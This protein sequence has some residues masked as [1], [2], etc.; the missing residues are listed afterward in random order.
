MK[1]L[2][3]LF[4]ND[5]IIGRTDLVVTKDNSINADELAAYIRHLETENRGLKD[6]TVERNTISYKLG[7]TIIDALNNELPRKELPAKLLDLYIES[8]KRKLPNLKNAGLVDK[9]LILLNDKELLKSYQL[10]TNKTKSSDRKQLANIKQSDT[11]KLAA[12]LSAI[13]A[14]QS[15]SNLS[16]ESKNNKEY[17]NTDT[18]HETVR[19]T[20]STTSKLKP[21][22]LVNT[23]INNNDINELAQIEVSAVGDI[24]ELSAA[25]LYRLKS[26]V[27]S[28]KA[29][30]LLSFF[31]SE[32][33]KVED[34]AL[35]DIG[36]SAAFG[37]HFRYLN[38][39]CIDITE[40]LKDIVKFEIPDG[41]ASIKI[42]VAAMGLKDE[43]QIDIRLNARCY[44]NQAAAKLKTEA[45]TAATIDD[46]N[47]NELTQI[48]VPAAGDTLEVVAAVSYCVKSNIASR[49]AVMLLSF[50]D[51]KGSKV[52]DLS[53]SGIGVSAAFEQ[54]FRYL[55]NNCSDIKESLK[56]I[57]KFEVPE[58]I[59]SIK[60]S[61][62][63]MGLSDDEKV[64]IRL[65][66]RCYNEQREEDNY[67][68]ALLS[69]PL[70]EPT[71]SDPHSKRYTS[72][73]NI[74]CILDEFTTEC[75]AYE[76]NLT[77]V[78]QTDWQ[79]Q[80][81]DTH[82]DFLLVESCWRGNDGD[83]GTL[84]KG[85]GGGKKLS[86]LLQ[87]CKKKNIPTVFWNKEDPPHYEKF[88]AIAR[89]FDVAITT[90]INMVER[91]KADFG[92]DVYPLSFGAQPKIHNPTFVIPKS[93]KAVFAGSYYGDK[94]QRCA[95]FNDIMS[96][97]EVAQVDYDIFDRNYNRD[98]EK[99]AFPNRYQSHIL[100][101]LPPEDI[102]KVH[103]GYKYQVNMNTVQDSATMFA[104]RVYESLA[105]GTPVITNDSVGVRE[106][107]GDLVIMPTEHLSVSE[108]LMQLE[109][110]PSIYNEIARLGVRRVMREHTYGHRIQQI[111]KLLGI[112]VEVT[113]PTATLAITVNSEADI[114][115]AKKIFAAQT[116][117]D[118]KLFIELENFDTAYKYL[119]QS[120]ST[121]SYAMKLG[122]AFYSEEN[123]YYGGDK[124]LKCNVNEAI[125][126]E[127]L[128]DFTYWG[129]K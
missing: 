77:K 69:K 19:K 60:I 48:E 15:K 5:A 121:V 122:S 97:L 84:T 87:Y 126:A 9:T 38:N 41:I 91:Y 17:L 109:A 100:G 113:V 96:Q 57:I 106:L 117:S 71:I 101:T 32:A 51:N 67:R 128:E 86:P 2:K 115:R 25:V 127:A 82:I 35:S 21:E 94:P 66:A 10:S 47:V 59:A 72:D 31:D 44:N 58:G 26:N 34:I 61:V 42:S 110:S 98:I 80:M 63:G 50:F 125:S 120:D 18:K 95:D 90:D 105:S 92:I 49:K 85:S 52:K 53:L 81:E 107:F 118:K 13:K 55:N 108:Q 45:L 1:K 4:K 6:T 22:I 37:Q 64:D 62:A 56:D 36:V 16:L 12:T 93:D 73:L 33:K 123:Q 102:W 129:E 40:S 24:L 112:D 39:N 70:P 3:E 83:W 89:L 74:A 116:A 119:N 11:T 111:C 20:N 104:R 54:H 14:E 79:S 124:V 75:L 43:E 76:V 30:V 88:G 7:K 27:I 65:K 103:K 46:N 23:T 114:T 8:R 28:R 78:T 29:V 68:H 99:F